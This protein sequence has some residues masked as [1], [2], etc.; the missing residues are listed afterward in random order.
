M[1]ILE[2]VNSGVGIIIGQRTHDG[3]IYRR[4]YDFLHKS[5]WGPIA[6][7]GQ[8]PKMSFGPLKN[9]EINFNKGHF[10]LLS[11]GEHIL[12]FDD[13]NLPYVDVLGIIAYTGEVPLS[14]FVVDNF[15]ISNVSEPNT[16]NLNVKAKGK[17]TVLWGELK[18][19]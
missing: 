4:T 15:I 17:T 2:A 8:N 5:I 18:D 19:R 6:F 14:H 11:E 3:N 12:D 9:I 1:D 7:R 16:E 13:P 10:E